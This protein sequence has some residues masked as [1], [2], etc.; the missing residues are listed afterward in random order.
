MATVVSIPD[1]VALLRR[2]PLFAGLPDGDLL[3]LAAQC[4]VDRFETNA[5]IFRQGDACDRFWL[6]HTGRVKIVRHE[7]A[8]REVILEIIPQGEVFGGATIFLPEQPA[9][10]QALTEAETLSLSAPAYAQFLRDHP[11]VALKLIRMLGMRLQSLMEMNTL[12][13][14]RVERR[15]AHILLKLASRSGRPDPEGVLITA[16]FSRQDL[17]DMSGT[18]L[19]TAIRIVSRFRADGLLKTRR[20]G[21][22]V[23]LDEA[24]L[25]HIAKS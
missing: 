25:R 1:G 2:L 4:R 3:A 20:G 8:G 22:I 24:R 5:V 18:T 6:V 9:T 14:E 16:P 13:G 12:A 23:L 7:E 17:A 21:Y 10:A 15:L 11:L 19:E